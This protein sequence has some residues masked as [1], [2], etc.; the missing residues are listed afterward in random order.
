MTVPNYTQ[1]QINAI[2][3]EARTAAYQAA[4]RFFNEKLGGQ[5]RYSCGF[6]WVEIFGVKGNTKLGKMLKAAGLRKDFSR[7]FTL[8]NPAG[9]GCQNVDTLEEGADAA[10][11]VF[12]KHGFQAY[13]ASRLD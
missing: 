4:D 1:A 12:V 6:A 3:T 9:Y 7:T 5:D 8:W 2:V 10:A 11:A 13:A